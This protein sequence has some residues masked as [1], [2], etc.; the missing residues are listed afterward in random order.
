MKRVKAFVLALTVFALF[1][2]V[3]GFQS[4]FA[5]YSDSGFET[6]DQGIKYRMSDGSYLTSSWLTIGSQKWAFDGNGILLTGSHVIDGESW[7]LSIEGIATQQETSVIEEIPDTVQ[8]DNTIATQE[9]APVAVNTDSAMYNLCSSILAGCTTADMTQDQ[10]LKAAYDYVVNNTT[11][12]RTYET[13]SGDW[14]AAYATELLTTGKGNCYRFAA[15]F[16]YLAKAL[17]YD[18]RVITGKIGAARGGLNPHGWVEI[19][20]GGQTYVFDP[21]MHYAKKGA[22]DYFFKTY[23]TYPS[24]PLVKEIEWPVNF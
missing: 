24:K 17:G 23:A 4:A 18:S 11:Y 9:A 1:I 8:A 3:G 6:T 22:K 19:I 7:L 12:N 15:A 14:T 20:I 2:Y 13:P 5:G 16:A 21:E 10:K